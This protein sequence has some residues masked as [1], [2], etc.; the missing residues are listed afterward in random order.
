MRNDAAMFKNYLLTA[1]RSLARR[2]GHAFLNITGLAVGF[3]AFLLIFLVVNYE[4]SFDTFHV[5]KDRIFRVV[6]IGRNAANGEYGTGVPLPVTEALRKDYPQLAYV[7]CI[8]TDNNAPV[9][10]SEKGSSTQKKFKEGKGVFFAEPQFFDMFSF[11]TVA[12]D[13]RSLSM[14]GNILLTQSTADRYFGDWHGAMGKT[15]IM[16]GVPVKVTGILKDMPANTDFQIKE[17]VSYTTLHHYYNFNDWRNIDDDNQCFVQ[18]GANNSPA[19]V[20][21]SL[22]RFTDKYIKPVGDEY[23]LS[24]QPLGNIHFDARH[25]NYSGRGFSKDLIFALSVIGIF[26]LVIACVNFINLSTAQAVNR[27]KEVGVRKVL[28]GTRGQLI[29]QFLGE[30]AVI[31]FIALLFSLLVAALSVPAINQLL[32][33]RLAVSALYDGKMVACIVVGLAAVI[34]LSG[35]YPAFLLSRFNAVR[36]LKGTLSVQQGGGISLRRVLVVLQF[37]IAQSLIIGTL[38]VA[39]QMNYFTHAD[40]GFSKDAII[41]APFPRDSAG[42]ASQDFL[43]NELLKTPGVEQVSLSMAV[44]IVGGFETDLRTPENKSKEPNMAVRMKVTD[45]SYFSLYHIP[46]VAG[47]CYHQSDTPAEFVISQRVARQLGYRDPWQAIGKRINILGGTLPIVG[48]VKDFH[49]ASFR[50]SIEPVVLTCFKREFAVASVKL[51]MAKAQSV[52]ASMKKIWESNYPDLTFEYAFLDQTIANFYSQENQLSQL[53]KVFAAMA[54][55]IS[56][57]GL[58]G[59]IS[60]I[61]MQRKKEIGIRKVLGAPIKSILMLLSKE[62]TLLITLAFLISAPLAWYFMHQWL[63]QYPYRIDLGPWFFLATMGGSLLIAWTTV[64]YTAL[65]AA[66]ANP[67]E[68]LRTD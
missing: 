63:R 25:G 12:G 66:R 17:V 47:R 48:V 18:L 27:A 53:Y 29:A 65:H 59:L 15:F 8:T 61:T 39:S 23:L 67:V 13:H 30:A 4:E 64:G 10:I 43:R 46:F 55:F 19:A 2:K 24:L 38:V 6:R 35:F 22:N 3:A 57:L 32:D 51:N 54:L 26:L 56:C 62:F 33:I 34:G 36:V 9:I 31:S 45:A 52:I 58:Y 28:G 20:N 41:T 42:L 40:M 50:D 14:P 21:F 60:F 68:S 16:D 11:P 1:F 44:P 7:G 5:N 37:A 49:T